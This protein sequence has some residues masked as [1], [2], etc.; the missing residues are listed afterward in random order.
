[1]S[2]HGWAR[3]AREDES[4]VY[5]HDGTGC[6]LQKV[7]RSTARGGP[8][9]VWLLFTRTYRFLEV[10]GRSRDDSPPFCEAEPLLHRLRT[11]VDAEPVLAT[12]DLHG[13]YE[14]G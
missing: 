10:F 13:A 4:V 5:R 3:E 6:T 12:V 8:A 9:F 7:T 2:A 1:M 14:W 11:D